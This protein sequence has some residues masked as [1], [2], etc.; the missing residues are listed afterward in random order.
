MTENV[1]T[2]QELINEA[3]RQTIHELAGTVGFNYGVCQE[4]L[5]ENLNIHRIAHSS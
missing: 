3:C 2:I 1:E 5:I 4:M